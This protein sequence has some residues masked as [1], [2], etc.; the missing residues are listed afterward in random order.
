L[1]QQVWNRILGLAHL[2]ENVLHS[3]EAF[4]LDDA[5]DVKI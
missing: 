1:R 2:L 3:L 4:L 5:Q